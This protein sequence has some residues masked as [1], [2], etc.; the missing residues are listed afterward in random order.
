[1]PLLIIILL[2]A[3]SAAPPVKANVIPRTN[4]AKRITTPV[5]TSTAES[6]L[7]P[8]ACSPPFQ[9]RHIPW[10]ISLVLRIKQVSFRVCKSRDESTDLSRDHVRV[11]SEHSV[12]SFPHANRTHGSP[13]APY[14]RHV[15]QSSRTKLV[16]SSTRA[17]HDRAL[18]TD[19]FRMRNA[20]VTSTYAGILF[21]F[22]SRKRVASS[23]HI[24]EGLSHRFVTLY[25]LLH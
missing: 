18:R 9:K 25:R 14:C 11:T 20:A 12:D 19:T 5:N 6:T 10:L 22:V 21:L 8:S 17:T 15:N 3:T 24:H 4:V 16:R 2:S 1:V 13:I 23:L 7:A